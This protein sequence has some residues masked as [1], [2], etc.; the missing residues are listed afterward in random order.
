MLKFLPISQKIPSHSSGSITRHVRDFI[1]FI[2]TQ[3]QHFTSMTSNRIMQNIGLE[4]FS[5]AV[6]DRLA[7]DSRLSFFQQQ[8]D[9]CLFHKLKFLNL[10][11]S[12]ILE[13]SVYLSDLSKLLTN[14]SF[15]ESKT[16]FE[17][18]NAVWMRTQCSYS[19]LLKT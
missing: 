13:F 2:V 7:P 14:Y 15:Q 5:P 8:K 4:I 6:K 18:S 12:Q 17:L 9:L 11:T 3:N 16:F 10:V 19:W 1:Y